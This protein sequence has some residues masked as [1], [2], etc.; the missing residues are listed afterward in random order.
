MDIAT[1]YFSVW[2]IYEHPEFL[3]TGPKGW[4]NSRDLF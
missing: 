4:E 1:L 3:C 2:S